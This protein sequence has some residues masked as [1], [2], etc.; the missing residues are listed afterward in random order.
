MK[1]MPCQYKRESL[2]N[3]DVDKLIN[4]CNTF[5]KKFLIGKARGHFICH[6]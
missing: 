6:I 2:N 4:A 1:S 5:R 3:D